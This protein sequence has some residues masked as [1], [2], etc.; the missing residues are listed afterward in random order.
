M[1]VQR[2]AGWTQLGQQPV[3]LRQW[4]TDSARWW[5]DPGLRSDSK[6]RPS[7]NGSSA[8]VHAEQAGGKNKEERVC[9]LGRIPTCSARRSVP[10]F[11]PGG[12]VLIVLAA[13]LKKSQWR[14]A[15]IAMWVRCFILYTS[16]GH[17]QAGQST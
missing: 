8:T 16:G 7:A 10:S 2:Q 4:G 13:D 15:D 6:S 11:K 17:G 1:P 14:I 5:Q 9:R 3:P 12:P